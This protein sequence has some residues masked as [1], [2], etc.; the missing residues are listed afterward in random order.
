MYYIY[1]PPPKWSIL[2]IIRFFFGQLMVNDVDEKDEVRICVKDG[3]F[4]NFRRYTPVFLLGATF[5]ELDG[6]IG[7]IKLRGLIRD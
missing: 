6:L 4:A 2:V 5:S 1:P 7:F 3:I